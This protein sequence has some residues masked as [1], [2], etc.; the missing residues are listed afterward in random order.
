MLHPCV[1][2]IM[3][4]CFGFGPALLCFCLFPY[5][6]GGE[7]A[8]LLLGNLTGGCGSEG[9]TSSCNVRNNLEDAW[10]CGHHRRRMA[11]GRDDAVARDNEDQRGMVV[12]KLMRDYKCY[13]SSSPQETDSSHA[14]E[15][16]ADPYE[17]KKAILP[18]CVYHPRN[19]LDRL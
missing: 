16:H 12:F 1:Y 10:R 2:I 11:T 8:L 14:A 15:R 7:D 13:T 9:P 5:T 18:I 3:Y 6:G 4:I 17:F 19:C